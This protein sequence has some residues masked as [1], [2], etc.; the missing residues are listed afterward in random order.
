MIAG[1]GQAAAPTQAPAPT[2]AAAPTQAPAPTEA[3][4]PTQAPAAEATQAPAAKHY[5]V[6][7]VLPGAI[8]DQGY[9]AAA[10]KG[11][12]DLK[13]KYGAEVAYSESVPIA[14]YEETFRDYSQKGYDIVIGHGFE[15]GDIIK[16]VAP[17]FPDTHYWCINCNVSGPNY[18]SLLHQNQEGSFVAGYLAA[19]MSKTGKVAG[20]AG[21]QFPVLVQ[22]MEAFKQGALWANPKM[23]VTITY[24][25]T[26]DDI[27]KGKEAALAQI[28]AG[29]DVIFHI[30]DAAGVG[31]IEACKEKGVY[32]IGFAWDQNQL[33]P[34]TVLTSTIISFEGMMDQAMDATIKGTFTM[35]VHK[36]GLSTGVVQ[37]ADYHGLVPDDIAAKVKEV[38]DKIEAGKLHVPVINDPTTDNKILATE[39][40]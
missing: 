27:A 18:A 3:A 16:K 35:D 23:Q 19:L 8:S 26:N 20:I 17:D 33:A 36:Y 9:N 12:M 7:L 24:I 34:K 6:A 4:Q 14:E 29:N 31:V 39:D 28:S 13:D 30:A 2:Q 1:C 25:G 21:V 15:F 5:K 22:Q 10:Y 40:Q 11:L 37:L 32:A 38:R